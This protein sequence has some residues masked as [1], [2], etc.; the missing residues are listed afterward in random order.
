MKY[1]KASDKLCQAE[2]LGQP[3]L[4]IR[5]IDYGEAKL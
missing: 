1:L 2:G 4:T 3:K 5:R